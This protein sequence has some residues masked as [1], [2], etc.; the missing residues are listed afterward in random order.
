MG[1]EKYVAQIWGNFWE[2]VLHVEFDTLNIL[3][4]D[5]MIKCGIGKVRGSNQ[6]QHMRTCAREVGSVDTLVLVGMTLL[7]S[8]A[9]CKK[10][11]Q[12]YKKYFLLRHLAMHFV[13]Q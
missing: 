11:S 12:K 13:H 7:K 4:W 1:M 3:L 6:G 8:R 5:G 2:L 10:N 9:A